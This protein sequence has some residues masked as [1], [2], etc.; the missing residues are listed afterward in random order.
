[1]ANSR[2]CSTLGERLHFSYLVGNKNSRWMIVLSTSP[3]DIFSPHSLPISLF[4]CAYNRGQISKS[5]AYIDNQTRNEIPVCLYFRWLWTLIL[6]FWIHTWQLLFF[7]TEKRGDPLLKNFMFFSKSN[8]LLFLFSLFRFTLREGV[9][10]LMMGLVQKNWYLLESPE[11][12]GR[13]Q[14]LLAP[15][16]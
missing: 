2:T 4:P 13:Y 15:W 10:I 12:S 9:T 6:T 8:K 16:S 14:L 7:P 3:P 5:F 11:R 1:M